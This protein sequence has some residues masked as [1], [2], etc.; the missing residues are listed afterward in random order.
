MKPVIVMTQTSEFETEDMTILHKP[1]IYVE[2]LSFDLSLLDVNYDWFIFTSKNAV[3]LFYPRMS[4]MQDTK[5]AV[6]GKK[7]AHYCES[8]G[9][10]VD[11]IPSDY[12]QEGFLKQFNPQV[13]SRILIPSSK[14]ARPLLQQSLQQQGHTVRKID[15]YQPLPHTENINEV[16]RLIETNKINAITFASTSAVKYFFESGEVPAFNNYFVI[17]QQTFEALKQ[18][19]IQATMADKQTLESL[20]NIIRES[21]EK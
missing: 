7:T 1:L 14:K 3:K 13:S 19:G 11:F 9:L 18:F 10:K 2:P 21:W 20:I 15:L 12:S 16:K 6:I 4:Q 8:L 5:I 17:G